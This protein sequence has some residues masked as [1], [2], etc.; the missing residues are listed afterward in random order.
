MSDK[1]IE[2]ERRI[3]SE[4]QTLAL[5]L[6]ALVRQVPVICHEE[7]SAREAATIM[8]EHGVG[9]V[10]VMNSDSRPVGIFTERDLVTT[11]AKGAEE[12]RISDQ[13][14]RT[15]LGLPAHAFAYEAAIIM[16]SN[17]IRH[18]LVME[19]SELI[20]VVSERDL[21]SLQRLGLGELT[22]RIR[23][24]TELPALQNI[25]TDI[26]KLARLLVNQGVAAEQLT[27]FISALNDRLCQ[28]IIEVVRKCHQWEKIS[29]CW[30][31]FGSEGRLEQ[32]FSTDQDNGIIFE[33]HDATDP[34]EVRA[35][36]LPFA[37]DVNKMLDAC[38]FRWCKGNVMAS[39]PGLCLSLEEWQVKMG[40]WLAK[41]EP[42]ALLDASIYFDFRP[43]FGDANLA[44]RLRRWFL[45]RAPAYPAF[46][47]QMAQNALLAK[48]ALG[49][50]REFATQDYPDSPHSIDLKLYG[51]RLFVDAARIYA[52]A[53][54]LANTSTVE[55]L[56]AAGPNTRMSTSDVEAAVDAFLAI[57]KL[58]LHHQASQEALTEGTANRIDPAKL[59]ELQRQLLKESLRLARKLQQCLALDYQI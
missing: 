42:Q 32:T 2:L 50:L 31:G 1:N 48:P 28:R 38:G 25:A 11:I 35:R 21:F 17:R 22:A 37:R 19:E 44:V 34:A 4:Q 56:R 41:W 13:M 15:P 40:G 3:A 24:A 33:A 27:L 57:Q 55:R 16:I 36:L 54:G 59:N 49:A 46:L 29:W 5:P 10:I 51:A 43:L 53:H 20:G 9:F 18:I 6:R 58:R 26:R 7:Q 8:N 39:N 47:R 45:E 23:T 30:L 12:A 52:L 14:T